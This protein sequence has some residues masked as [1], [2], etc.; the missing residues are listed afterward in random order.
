MRAILMVTLAA[1]L[2]GCLVAHAADAAGGTNCPGPWTKRCGV[3]TNPDAGYFHGL[4]AVKGD[5]WVLNDAARSGTKPGCGDCTWTIVVACPDQSPGNPG[6]THHCVT[7]GGAPQCRPGQL[8]YRVYLTTHAVTDSLQ[9]VICLGDG[10]DPIPIGTDAA[11][12]VARY[13]KNVIPPDDVIATIPNDATLAGLSTRFRAH[14]PGS[15][16]PVPFGGPDLTESITIAPA[17]SRWTW[18][19]GETSGW[20]VTGRTVRHVFDRGGV[21]HG[22][23][24]TRWRATYTLSFGGRTFGP[25]DAVGRVTKEQSFTLPVRTS[26][27]VL[28]SG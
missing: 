4:I 17:T 1:L 8:L 10:Q 22:T 5:P 27:P 25:Y 9:G 15:L 13:M 11:A 24:A 7:A 3:G 20:S 26:S 21:D 12:D 28:V 6:S 18:G 19:P 2:A 23:L 14:P 16:R